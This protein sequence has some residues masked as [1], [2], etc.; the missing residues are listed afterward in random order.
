MMGME[1]TI[2]QEQLEKLKEVAKKDD[3]GLANFKL[4]ENKDEKE[5]FIFRVVCERY[6]ISKEFEDA[7]SEDSE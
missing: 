6:N 2:T 4:I 1:W 7:F 5:H 3:E